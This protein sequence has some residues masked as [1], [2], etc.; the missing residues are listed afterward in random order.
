VEI[1]SWWA[2]QDAAG[3]VKVRVKPTAEISMARGDGDGEPN[4]CDHC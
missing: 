3:A 1:A 2:C 4:S